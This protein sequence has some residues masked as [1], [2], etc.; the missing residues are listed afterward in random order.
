[1][2]GVITLGR[3]DFIP[4]L[5]GSSQFVLRHVELL[6]LNQQSLVGNATALQYPVVIK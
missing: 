4:M 6:D 2:T 3:F 1:M 5:T